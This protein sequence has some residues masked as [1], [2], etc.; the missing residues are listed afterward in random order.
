MEDINDYW[1]MMEYPPLFTNIDWNENQSSN[2]FIP[3][4]YDQQKIP[5]S[6]QHQP[7]QRRRSSSVDLPIN[8][9]YSNT[10]R[11]MMGNNETT[12]HEEDQQQLQFEP[13]H[14]FPQHPFSTMRVGSSAV[15]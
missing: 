2:S 1:K 15:S 11:Y 12:I 8:P 14:D 7:F 9:L 6:Y 5:P 10:N 3:M 4:E 13:P